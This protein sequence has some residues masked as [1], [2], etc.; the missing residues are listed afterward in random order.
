LGRTA[1]TA[2]L[3]GSPFQDRNGQVQVEDN[4]HSS[5]HA[6]GSTAWHVGE[7]ALKGPSGKVDVKPE[8]LLTGKYTS[9]FANDWKSLN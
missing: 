5:L 4:T 1:V 9:A 7:Y 2:R 6:L 3:Q 8:A